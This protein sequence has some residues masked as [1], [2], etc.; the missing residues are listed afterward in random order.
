MHD[1]TDLDKLV[2]EYDKLKGLLTDY[3]DDL[4]SQKRRGKT[5]KEKQVGERW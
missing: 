1:T 3:V 4:V 2:R 5:L